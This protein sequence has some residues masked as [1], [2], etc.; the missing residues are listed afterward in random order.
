[1]W[2]FMAVLCSI[3]GFVAAL[4]CYALHVGL[5]ATVIFT[6]ASASLVGIVTLGVTHTVLL[7]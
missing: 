2:I 6:L 1:M 4:M 7:F 3:A 5:K